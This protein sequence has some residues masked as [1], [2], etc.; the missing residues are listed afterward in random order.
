MDLCTKWGMS[1]CIQPWQ[2]IKWG[3]FKD[4]KWSRHQIE[5]FRGARDFFGP[6]N[7]TNHWP[8]LVIWQGMFHK[9]KSH[10]QHSCNGIFMQP[11]FKLFLRPFLVFGIS[12]P[13]C[14]IFEL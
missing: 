14:P 3:Q 4:S 12:P 11:V 13:P 8:H 9:T 6:L 5:T 7:G 10:L 2:I 1:L